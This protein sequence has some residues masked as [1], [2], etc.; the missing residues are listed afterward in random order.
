[1]N[2]KKNTLMKHSKKKLLIFTTIFWALLCLISCNSNKENKGKLEILQQQHQKL[3]DESAI[4]N[5]IY[6]FSDA[7]NRK[8][9]A[10]FQS[11]WHNDGVWKIGP[12]INMEFIGKDNMGTSVTKMLG[13]WDFFVQM[14]TAMVIK[15][16]GNNAIARVYI[17]EVARKSDDKH[18]NYNLSM[19]E[20]E[21]IKE[22]DNWFF[23]KRT[24]HTRYQDA[25]EYK[26]LVQE[27]PKV[28]ADK[29][30]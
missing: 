14:P 8:D 2:T 4:R 18:G 29:N 7:A 27:L 24:Y 22:Q 28:L 26:G 17:N 21:L 16:N 6:S 23:R 1:M 5:L 20:D 30:E 10:L 13:L 12:P 9:G 3:L 15:I 11:L 19:Y 25:P